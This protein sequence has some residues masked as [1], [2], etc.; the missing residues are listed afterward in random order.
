[1]E[2]GSR[3][4]HSIPILESPPPPLSPFCGAR[5]TWRLEEKDSTREARRSA[6]MMRMREDRARLGRDGIAMEG[7]HRSAYG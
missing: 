4:H 7:G 2:R 6:R 5:K 3:D 1:M